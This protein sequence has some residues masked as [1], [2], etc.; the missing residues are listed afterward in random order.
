M[1]LNA[2]SIYDKKAAQYMR[3]FYVQNEHVAIRSI[4][5]SVLSNPELS[6]FPSDYSLAHVGSFD[7][8]NGLLE[9]TPVKIISEISVIHDAATAQL[10]DP[11][12]TQLPISS[13]KPSII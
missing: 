3:P 9:P 12:Q 7:E 2:F 1:K 4:T 10:P 8:S 11:N 5:A 13:P 6:Q